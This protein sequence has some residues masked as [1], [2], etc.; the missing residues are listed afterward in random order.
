MMLS[1][2]TPLMTGGDEYLRS[3]HCNNNPYN[4]DSIAN[5]LSYSWSSDQSNFAAFVKN[6]IAFRKA[7]AALRPMQ[8]YSSTQLVWWTPAGTAPDTHYC[9]SSSN[10]A[11]AFQFNGTAL[12]DTASSIYV[13]YNGWSGDVNFTLPSPGNSLNWYRVTDTCGW[14]EGPNQ[15]RSPGAEDFIGGG[16][17]VY[18]ECGR[19]L[20]LLIA[21]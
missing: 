17:V 18:G 2:G 20:L 11:I 16:G 14:A 15:V 5:W 6:L 19:G 7:H 8:F 1:A 21:K 9:D 12:Q 3:L 4:V 13:A 10:D